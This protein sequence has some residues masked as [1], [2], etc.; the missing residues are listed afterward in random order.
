VFRQEQ[1]RPLPQPAHPADAKHYGKMGILC[2]A[3]GS[4]SA[5][6]D[7]QLGEHNPSVAENPAACREHLSALE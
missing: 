6:D 7:R 3:A 1:A 2:T 5:E 4:V